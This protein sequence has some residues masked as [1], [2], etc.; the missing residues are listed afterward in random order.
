MVTK[1]HHHWHSR[2]LFIMAATGS[3]VGL[4]NIWKFPY[5]AGENGG[6]AFVLI[7]LACIVVI[8]VPILM[9]ET[10]LG[11]HGDSNPINAMLKTTRDSD[12]SKLWTIIAIMGIFCG[13]FIMFFYSVVAG[14]VLDYI[15]AIAQGSFQN[16]E[17]AFVEQYFEQE[18]MANKE[19]QLVGHTIFTLLTVGV[20]A[21]GINKGLGNAIKIL[22][23]LLFILLGT[24]LVFSI[25]SGNFMQG[26][27]FLFDPD[28]SKVTG[29]VVLMAMGQAFFS[30]SV[31]MGAIMT[32][33]SYMDK[34]TSIARTGFI[35]AGLDTL[36]ALMAGLTIFPLVFA[37][38]LQPSEGPGLMFLSLPIAFGH[39][40][41]GV[42]FGTL[43]FVLI[44]VAAWSS[45][46]SL[47]EPALSWIS[48][49]TP[50]NRAF[51]CILLAIIVW[52][53][54][55]ACIYQEGVF[56]FFD[57]LTS[58]YLLPIGGLLIAV[59]TGWVMKRKIAKNQLSQ[60][61]YFQFNLWY[62]TLRVFC[63]LGVI[64]VLI[65][66]LW[67]SIQALFGN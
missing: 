8:G 61:S 24:S 65:S 11:R 41:G 31:G 42:I 62:A 67:P 48:E 20:L 10:L 21:F 22:M 43:F 6:A 28:F 57:N 19:R 18:I 3:A 16:V 34:Q 15:V 40:E 32:Y 60:L 7:Y 50:L 14:W 38:G 35:V 51:A 17:P 13:L 9:A 56:D 23:P 58:N 59:F 39:M 49:K 46:I 25:Q 45:S 47:I 63:P 54:G 27:H 26:F 52:V 4:G 30:L 5:V 55:Y 2:W 1:I 33:G 66:G 44:G 36:V 29:E 37:N 64:A 53:G 12:V